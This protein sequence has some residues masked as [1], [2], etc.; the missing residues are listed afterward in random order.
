[1]WQEPFMH[2]LGIL[3][4]SIR[5]KCLDV[6]RSATE[7]GN[8]PVSAPAGRA[9][10]LRVA[11]PATVVAALATAELFN[12]YNAMKERLAYINEHNLYL[13]PPD[14]IPLLVC[15]ILVAS[16]TLLL[17]GGTL[18]VATGKRITE[19]PRSA[20]SQFK[21]LIKCT[22]ARLDQSSASSIAQG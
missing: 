9:L 7:A 18:E 1:M 15:A 11:Y 10:V 2:I 16:V 17:I 22:R 4:S 13:S 6:K 21:E 12:M 14:P 5:Q 3:Y 8:S 19:L 20:A